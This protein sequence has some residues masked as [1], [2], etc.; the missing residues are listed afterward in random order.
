M[1]D[2]G[3]DVEIKK[4]AWEYREAAVTRDQPKHALTK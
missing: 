2:S 3:P 4:C 1:A